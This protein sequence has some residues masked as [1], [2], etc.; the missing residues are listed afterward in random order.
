MSTHHVQAPVTQAG[1]RRPWRSSRDNHESSADWSDSAQGHRCGEKATGPFIRFSCWRTSCSPGRF[2]TVRSMR[3][4]GAGRSPV[5]H[6]S[7]SGAEYD[8][9]ERTTITRPGGRDA[10]KPL[11]GSPSMYDRERRWTAGP[12]TCRLGPRTT[13]S[14]TVPDALKNRPC[15]RESCDAL[16]TVS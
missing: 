3:S 12:H 14:S 5:V 16:P 13:A 6:L 7:T 8:V 2:A 4:L 11:V 9:A 1:H 10:Q 15:L